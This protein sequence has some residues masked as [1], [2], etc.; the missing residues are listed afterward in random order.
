VLELRYDQGRSF[1][2]VGAAMGRSEAAAKKLWLRAVRRLRREVRC[3]HE[4]V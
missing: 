2:E 4:E 1:A 3:E